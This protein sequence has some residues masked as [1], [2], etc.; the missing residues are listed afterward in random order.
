LQ[1]LASS[2]T[3]IEVW[4]IW[5]IIS[6]FFILLQNGVV[7]VIARKRN[8][9]TKSNPDEKD[10]LQSN[11]TVRKAFYPKEFNKENGT[12][13]R[14]DFAHKIDR[15]SFLVCLIAF[16]IFNILFWYKYL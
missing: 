7:M 16:A 13:N 2:T 11:L 15:I 4:M 14:I 8:P 6:T 5:C 10:S 1:N 3:A 12:K 9:E